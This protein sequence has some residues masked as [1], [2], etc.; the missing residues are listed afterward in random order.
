MKMGF[1]IELNRKA[2]REMAKEE[3]HTIL[4]KALIQYTIRIQDAFSKK[5][6]EL[7]EMK[8]L[9]TKF[10]T[11]A[12]KNTP[13]Y[14]KERVYKEQGEYKTPDEI[15][16]AAKQMFQSINPPFNG[17]TENESVCTTGDESSDDA[18]CD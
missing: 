3:N 2:I 17:K 10:F 1:H 8:M 5:E 14:I 7:N 15:I 13:P 11:F 6:C 18:L 4:E 16:E 9:L 12:H